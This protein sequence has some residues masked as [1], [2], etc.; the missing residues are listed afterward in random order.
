M[1]PACED[2]CIRKGV[3][4]SDPKEGSCIPWNPTSPEEANDDGL[5]KSDF[6]FNV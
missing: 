5:I 2:T 3:D 1:G 4:G 6:P